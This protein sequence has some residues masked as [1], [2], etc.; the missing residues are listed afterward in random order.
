MG[1]YVILF[2]AI[3][4]MPECPPFPDLCEGISFISVF[5]WRQAA[6]ELVHVGN[7]TG[8][9]QPMC[10]SMAYQILTKC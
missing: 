3:D 8:S 10:I 2:V 4:S 1:I 9:E 5:I 7:C 6:F